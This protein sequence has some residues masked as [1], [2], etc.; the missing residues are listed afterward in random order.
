VGEVVIA[1]GAR[2]NLVVQLQ[3]A[4]GDSVAQPDGVYGPATATAVRRAQTRNSLPATGEADPVTWSAV[5]NQPT[6]SL[7][8]RALQ[9]TATFEGHGFGLAQGNFDGAGITWGVIGFSRFLQGI[10]VPG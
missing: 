1:Q 9:L 7:L 8:D 10:C 5:T 3:R 6:P 4:L 2:G